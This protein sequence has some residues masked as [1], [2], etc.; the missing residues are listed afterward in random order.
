[1][2]AASMSNSELL[3]AVR[4]L[5]EEVKSLRTMLAVEYPK[6]TEMKS[7]MRRRA[8]TYLAVILLILTTT[9]A[10]TITTVSHCFLVSS[11]NPPFGCTVIPGYQD[12]MK[13]GEERLRRFQ[14]M[15]SEVE[16]NRI[17]LAELE[18]EIEKLKSERGTR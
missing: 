15:N 11:T 16:S 5:T 13:Q 9:Q 1:M 3:T 10:M 8:F 6:R 17:K 7:A 18:L 12:A 14:Q 4:E 2:V